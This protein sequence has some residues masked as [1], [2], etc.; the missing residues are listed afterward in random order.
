MVP[1]AVVGE[2]GVVFFRR[3]GGS[4]GIRGWGLDRRGG[5]GEGGGGVGGWRLLVG[6]I[7]GTKAVEII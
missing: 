7:D 1:Q 3:M 4:G 5:G 2:G 6:K